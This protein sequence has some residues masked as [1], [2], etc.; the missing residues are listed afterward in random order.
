[1]TELSRHPE[2]ITVWKD[3]PD[4]WDFYIVPQKI[5]DGDSGEKTWRVEGPCRIGHWGQEFLFPQGFEVCAL[6]RW[7]GHVFVL[8]LQ[9]KGDGESPCARC[10]ASSPLA[11]RSNFVYFFL[12]RS[13]SAETAAGNAIEEEH[14]VILDCWPE[15]LSLALH[16]WESLIADLPSRVL[17]DENCLGLCP[18]CGTNRNKEAC[19]CASNSGDPR[20]SQ[21][22]DVPI[23]RA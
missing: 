15:K 4:S 17:C 12:L 3:V 2:A 6:Y 16:A 9:V 7:D 11:I 22:L 1:M 19:S 10:L 21:L 23:N 13:A 18:H 8:N 20:L 14:M 5:G